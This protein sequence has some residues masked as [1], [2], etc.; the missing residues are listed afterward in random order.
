MLAKSL[1]RSQASRTGA[2]TE[3]EVQCCLPVAA[4]TIPIS[5]SGCMAFITKLRAFLLGLLASFI[6]MFIALAFLITNAFLPQ[7]PNLPE[8]P[9]KELAANKG[10]KIGNFAMPKLLGERPYT[11]ILTSQFEFVLADNQP[12]W[13][14]TDADLRPSPTTFDFSRVD[15]VIKFA[16][17][18]NMAVQAHHYIW[19]EEKWLPQ[20]LLNGG[21]N[22]Q[23]LLDLIHEHITAVG[24][25]YRGKVR[26]WSV[27]NEA[28]SRGQN[29]YGLHDWWADH[30][31]DQSYIDQAFIWARQAD[32]NSKLILN[33]FGNEGINDIS[34]AMYEYIKAAKARGVP[35]GGIGMQMHIDGTHPPTK[36]EVVA[37][38]KR[39]GDLGV[40]VYV[41]ELDVNMNDVKA[42]DKDRDQIQADIYYEMMRACIESKVC[43][44]FALLGI[45]DKETWYN[46]LP[47]VPDS[48]P[49]M[50]DKN[51]RPK[52]AFYSLRDA[53]QQP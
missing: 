33:D 30:I 13:H 51:Y 25:R 48:R 50:F 10:I 6:V 40:K 20:W 53:L 21:Y 3:R 14:F 1:V 19:G 39:F 4:T 7:T 23:Q 8:P 17:D 18:H 27:V 26:E 31:G 9:L 45:T 32:P 24:E 16:E 34:N 37:N 46:Y 41:T 11:D 52:P 5:Y 2:C 43:P 47:G 28:F 29:I 42:D 12:N 15:E 44:S 38:M 36:D 35:I 49:L 22:K